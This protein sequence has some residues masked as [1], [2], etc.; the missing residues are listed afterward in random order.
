MDIVSILFWHSGTHSRVRNITISR[1]IIPLN[2]TKILQADCIYQKGNWTISYIQTIFSLSSRF[3]AF[4]NLKKFFHKIWIELCTRTSFQ[5]FNCLL[6]GDM[7]F[8]YGLSLIMA[9]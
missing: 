6:F 5:F 7:P 4:D 1:K 3:L 9:S 2:I 8:L